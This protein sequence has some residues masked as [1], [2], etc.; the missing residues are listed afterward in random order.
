M[1]DNRLRQISMAFGVVSFLLLCSKLFGLTDRLL[2]Y[3]LA[4]ACLGVGLLLNGVYIQRTNRILG[5]RIVY[6]SVIVF[7]LTFVM[8]VDS[9]L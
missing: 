2:A 4:T 5:M 8:V 9:L 7:I 1:N 6:S 3:H